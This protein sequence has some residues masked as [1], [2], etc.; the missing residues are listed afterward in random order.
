ME[1]L[2][3]DEGLRTKCWR[4]PDI[5]TSEF[6]ATVIAVYTRC[7]TARYRGALRSADLNTQQGLS[8]TFRK[9]S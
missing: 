7:R 9:T 3:A 6:M 5:F 8:G 2:Q 4:I 1:R